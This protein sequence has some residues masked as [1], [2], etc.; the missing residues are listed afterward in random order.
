MLVDDDAKDVVV[1]C[2]VGSLRTE[3]PI[4]LLGESLS[5]S[6]EE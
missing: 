6:L 1:Y 3:S 4:A 2:V 5:L